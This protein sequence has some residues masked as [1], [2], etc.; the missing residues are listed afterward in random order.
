[1][2]TPTRPADR[3][4]DPRRR[5]AL[6]P[7]LIASVALLVGITVLD[8][9]PFLVVRYIAAIFAGIVAVFAFQAKQWGWLPV[10]AA[11]AVAWNPV[12]VIP[13]PEPGWLIAQYIAVIVFLLAGWF[14]RV[15]VPDARSSR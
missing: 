13:I 4:G 9:G 1:M 11:I 10:F 15:T 5:L 2:A 14:I 3:Y 7:A 12:F 6:A 8:D